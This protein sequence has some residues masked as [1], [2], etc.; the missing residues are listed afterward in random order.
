MANINMLWKIAL[1]CQSTAVNEHVVNLLLSLYTN[2]DFGMEHLIPT[3]EDQFIDKCCKII[4]EQLSLIEKRTPEVQTRLTEA[5]YEAYG[6]GTVDAS[7][8]KKVLHPEELR[9]MRVLGYLKM[10]VHHSERDGTN[11]LR[12]HSSL[13]NS[14]KLVGLKI[15][16]SVNAYNHTEFKKKVEVDVDS[17]LTLFEF[18]KVIINQLWDT[19]KPK[20]GETL[21]LKKHCT[22]L[23]V[24]KTGKVLKDADNGKTLAELQFRAGENFICSLKSDVIVSKVPLF[25]DEKTDINERAKYIFTT[26]FKDFAK[27]D[28]EDNTLLIMER[29]EVRNFIMIVTQCKSVD[30]DDGRIDKIIEHGKQ[31]EGKLLL[32]EFISFYRKNCFSAVETVR[33]NLLKYNYRNDLR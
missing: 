10:L 32:E 19:A 12:P 14:T 3:F 17:G 15:V 28:P 21:P 8:V 31:K 24:S 16:N 20:E 9:I 1:D 26:M 23:T 22:K 33:S 6:V 7:R 11:G 5:L 2:V 4:D 30:H 27:T 29:E 18:K 13:I 25:N